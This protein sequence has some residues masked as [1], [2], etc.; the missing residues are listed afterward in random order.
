MNVSLGV[1][2][3]EKSPLP[4]A[5]PMVKARRTTPRTRRFPILDLEGPFEVSMVDLGR[6][7]SWPRTESRLAGSAE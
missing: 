4:D 1:D 3:V 5:V 7:K 6:S 2:G